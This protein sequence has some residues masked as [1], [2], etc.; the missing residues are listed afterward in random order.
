MNETLSAQVN[1]KDLSFL[2]LP[3][4][5]SDSVAQ[6]V[7][8]MLLIAA[9]ILVTLMVQRRVQ[10]WLDERRRERSTRKMPA[11]LK[12]DEATLGTVDLLRYF[13]DP[14][15]EGELLKSSRFFEQAVDKLTP[16]A[17]D[18]DLAG[19]TRLRERLK[20][21]AANPE[22]DLVS[23]RQLLGDQAVRLMATVGKER[24]ELHTALLEVNERFL[25]I[26]FPYPEDLY[27][28]LSVHAKVNLIYWREG[29]GEWVFPVT[30]EP[31]RSGAISAFRC[32]HVLNTKAEGHRG[33]FRLAVDLPV[34]FT[35][36]TREELEEHKESG[37]ELSVRKGEGRLVDLSF[38]GVALV[39]AEPMPAQAIAQL[40]F[41][42]GG[43][44]VRMM[45]EVLAATPLDGGKFMSRGRFRGAQEQFR[46]RL[47]AFVTSEQE[48]RTENKES[49]VTRVPG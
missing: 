46:D 10:G 35:C 5:S 11:G 40:N 44:P 27:K 26:D 43:K 7:L 36:V 28:R 38:N 4:G 19:V 1:M 41:M 32:A 18:E 49:V 39:A 25:L 21:T 12:L 2:R 6:F 30:L 23:T 42:L 33:D 3:E 8:A 48:K 16:T 9:T 29:G 17:T 45:L 24:L 22:A 14:E 34:A 47:R 15:K 31:I 37:R 13:T 20:M